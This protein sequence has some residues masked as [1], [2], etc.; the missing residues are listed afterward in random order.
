MA[1]SFVVLFSF[2][3]LA[4]SV[5]APEWTLQTEKGEIVRLEDYKGKPLIIHFWAT[6]CPYC[7]KLQPGLESLYQ[8]YQ[9]DGLEIIGVSWWEDEGAEPQKTLKQRG[10]SFKT[11]I[12][13]DAV[14]K[15]YGVQGT[16]TTYFIDR[17]GNIV[18]K[19]TVSDPKSPKLEAAALTIVDK[20]EG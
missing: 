19:T 10:I 12:N 14:A 9:D 11:V 16:P 3:A 4:E 13:G 7:K 20:K 6:W 15:R 17:S 18:L 5:K 2:G 8:K 1:V